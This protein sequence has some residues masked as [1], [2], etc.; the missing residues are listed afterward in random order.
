MSESPP[1]VDRRRRSISIPR[2]L[3]PSL[4]AVYTGREPAET[5]LLELRQGGVITATKLDPLVRTLVGVITDPA[6]VV[7][8]EIDD[9]IRA[10]KPRLATIWS[11]QHAAV[12]GSVA[13]EGWFELIQI[14]PPL[15]PF[16][17]AQVVRLSPRSHPSFSGAFTVTVRTLTAVESIVATDPIRAERELS[18]AGVG[19][20]W[21]DR[22]LAALIM[23][24]SMWAVES[25]WLGDRRHRR[26]ARLSVL[27]GGFT[28]YWRLSQVDD[29]V[30]VTP[31]GFEDLLARVAA[32][33]PQPQS[34]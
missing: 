33:L 30:Q 11:N 19:P 13:R 9:L 22:F 3:M 5:A 27:D 28:G 18:A 8:A 25:V 1:I 10:A 14:E 6:L 16:H 15:L 21:V 32:L 31:C 24:R 23:R 4:L 29:E 26:E 17:L 12:V 2:R 20:P 34:W 7:T